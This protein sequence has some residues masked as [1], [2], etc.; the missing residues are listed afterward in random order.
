MLTIYFGGGSSAIVSVGV[1]YV[2]PKTTCLFPMWP[3][4]AKRLDTPGIDNRLIDGRKVVSPK[5][6]PHITPQKLFFSFFCVKGKIVLE[7]N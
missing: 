1:F 4:E 2:W 6:Q 5:H 7:L 3:R